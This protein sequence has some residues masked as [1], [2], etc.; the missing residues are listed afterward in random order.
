MQLTTYL[1][2]NGNCEAAFK[3]YAETLGGK[4]TSM[5]MQ[6]ES[7]MGNNVPAEMREKI[8]HV[9]LEAPDGGALIRLRRNEYFKNCLQAAGCR[10][11]S[12]R[13]SGRQ[14]SGCASINSKF[15]G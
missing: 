12:R 14:G 7:P 6:G 10:W 5:M 13:P 2:F 8:M 15:H 1:N 9:T 3:L 11:R 4:I